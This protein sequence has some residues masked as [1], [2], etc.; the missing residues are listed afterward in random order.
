MS[1]SCPMPYPEFETPGRPEPDPSDEEPHKCGSVTSTDAFKTG[2]AHP[3]V[4]RFLRCVAAPLVSTRRGDAQSTWMTT[5][6]AQKTGSQSPEKVAGRWTG[7]AV[8]RVAA[9]AAR[10]NAALAAMVGNR[11]M[12]RLARVALDGDRRVSAAAPGARLDAATCAKMERGFGVDFRNVR[13]QTGEDATR[14][15]RELG[16]AAYAEGET[17]GFAPERYAPGTPEGEHI[18]AHELAHVVQQRRGLTKDLSAASRATLEAAAERSAR[19]VTAGGF[20]PAPA[21]VGPAAP[22]VQAFDP[23]YHEQATVAGL[24]GIFT[25]AEI[26]KIYEGNWRRD[27]SQGS[28]LIADLV[29]TWKTLRDSAVATGKADPSLQWQLLKVV[30]KLATHPLDIADETYGG[31]QS[32]EHM[33]NPRAAADAEAEADA[34]WQNTGTM[35]EL[36]GYLLDARAAI[37]ERL[38]SAIRL[39]RSSWGGQKMDSGQELADAWARGEPPASYDMCDAHARR[40]KPPLGYGVGKDVSDPSISSAIV[41]SEVERQAA[42]MPGHVD[43]SAKSTRGFGSDPAIADDLGRAA[44]LIE[45]FFAHSNFVTLAA[46]RVTGK[47]I[48]SSGLATGTFKWVDKPH[49]L[50]GKLND[51]AN[52]IEAHRELI[53]LVAEDVVNELRSAA[54]AAGTA[55]WALRPKPSSHTRMAKDSPQAPGFAVA[56]ELAIQADQMVFSLVHR[57]MQEPSADDADAKLY[58]LFA[59][60]DAIVNVPSDVHP[61]RDVCVSSPAP[62][63]ATL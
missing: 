10:G 61:L 13:V 57:I 34:R 38:A 14:R 43:D 36:P 55:S 27:F 22:A 33:D 4:A 30:M 2:S 60:I 11:A 45:D 6:R 56:H 3:G 62:V 19:V 53:P 58:I 21:R 44:H 7:P 59:R 52:E 5:T 50:A 23:E 51:A 63:P 18:L 49:S 25:P 41:A 42:A 40:T 39:A 29:L 26:G 20:A 24:T 54:M 31:Y 28:P 9:D 46:E 12:A 15:T 48:A 37:K 16:V 32:W 8:A 35:G 17:I 47:T 1:R